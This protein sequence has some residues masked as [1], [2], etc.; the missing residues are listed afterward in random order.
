MLSKEPPS[1]FSLPP[2]RYLLSE[3]LSK[4]SPISA[5]SLTGAP[6]CY[7]FEEDLLRDELSP[8]SL[9]LPNGECE[10]RAES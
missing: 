1:F 8:L 4:E 7:L 3:R 5:M 9:A 10:L 2:Y 6:N